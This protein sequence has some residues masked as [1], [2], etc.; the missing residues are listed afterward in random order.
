[1]CL[2]APLV[3][4]YWSH[5]KCL[6][7]TTNIIQ[8]LIEPS[9]DFFRILA[10][11]KLLYFTIKKNIINNLSN[12]QR[13]VSRREREMHLLNAIMVGCQ[14]KRFNLFSIVCR[15]FIELDNSSDTLGDTQ[16]QEEFYILV[17]LSRIIIQMLDKQKLWCI[18]IQNTRSICK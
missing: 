6:Q 15:R 14:E 7:T 17:V 10:A 12:L 5:H 1:M 11:N 13:A 16:I 2:F 3:C 18:A 8:V 4:T 9:E